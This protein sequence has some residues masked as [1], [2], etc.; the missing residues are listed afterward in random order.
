MAA[1]ASAFP[2]MN[3]GVRRDGEALLHFVPAASG[4]AASSVAEGLRRKAAIGAA[5]T[6]GGNN[7]SAVNQR[8][9]APDADRTDRSLRPDH[10]RP[11]GHAGRLGAPANRAYEPAEHPDRAGA[12][13]PDAVTV[14][15]SLP[16]QTCRRCFMHAW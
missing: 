2:R 1:S 4:A 10:Q 8:A 7:A 12:A 3:C 13:R 6:D 14:C 5:E 16:V 15:K 11:A 9:D